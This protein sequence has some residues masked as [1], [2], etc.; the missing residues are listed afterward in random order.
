MSAATR[1]FLATWMQRAAWWAFAV[2]LVLSPFRARIELMARPVG[3]LYGDYTDVLLYWSDIATLATVALWLGSL[4]LRPRPVWFGPRLLAWPVAALLVVSWLGAPFGVDP[5][6]AAMTSLRFTVLAALGM[7]ICNELRSPARLVAPVAAMI[8]VQAAIGIG[9][10]VTQRSLGL[11]ALGE[12]ALD[13]RLGISVVTAGDGTRV[14]RAYGLTDHPNILGGIL[15]FGLIVAGGLAA[16]R[17]RCGVP[18]ALGIVALGT[19][20]LLVTFSRGSWL[21]L[22]AGVAAITA[23]LVLKADRPALRRLGAASAA[24]LIVATPF[25]MP[26][27]AALSAR[28]D[29]AASRTETRSID[30]RTAVAQATTDVI[31]AHPLLGVGAGGLP[32]AMRN[33]Q[34]AFHYAYQ[35]APVVLLDATADTGIVGGGAYL[36][37]L[38]LPWLALWHRRDRWTMELTVASGALAA[39]TVTGMLDYYT[40]TYSAGRIWFWVLFGLWAVAYRNAMERPARAD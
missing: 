34:P 36:A 37:L 25:V 35:P 18:L 32:E 10:V 7:Y 27:R 13:P 40:W 21:G 39:L 23:M 6:L 26:Y 19:V 1:A 22:L 4:A 33:A 16:T 11:G 17:L 24:G 30:E 20:A 3:T 31:A 5:V 28:T 12:R 9:Q 29:P 14:L 8:V 15:V 2:L 38:V